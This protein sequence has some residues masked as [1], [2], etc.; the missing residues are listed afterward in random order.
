MGGRA[1]GPPTDNVGPGG[2][3]TTVHDFLINPTGLQADY[4]ITD[5]AIAGAI[6]ITG[7]K[8]GDLVYTVGE[9]WHKPTT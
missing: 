3:A 6:K 1:R 5:G 7:S 8:W 2:P 4:T 9:G